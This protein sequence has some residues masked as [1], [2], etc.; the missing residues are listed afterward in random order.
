MFHY[1]NVQG[2]FIGEIETTPSIIRLTSLDSAFPFCIMGFEEEC[3]T[4]V[5]G[6]RTLRTSI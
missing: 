4:L 5:V 6:M 3:L 1:D 2:I